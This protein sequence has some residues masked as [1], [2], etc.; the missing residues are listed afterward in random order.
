MEYF[1]RTNKRTDAHDVEL[2]NIECS[3]RNI[4]KK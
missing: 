1:E 2:K 3:V 4:Y